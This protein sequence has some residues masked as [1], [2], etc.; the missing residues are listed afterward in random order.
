ML[1]FCIKVLTAHIFQ[2]T[3]TDLVYIL[4]D[5]RYRSKVFLSSTLTYAQGLRIKDTDLEL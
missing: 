3:Q 4:Y 1:K 2:I 5:D